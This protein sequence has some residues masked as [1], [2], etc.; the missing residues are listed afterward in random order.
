LKIPDEELRSALDE[1]VNSFQKDEL[2]Y[3]A[4]PGKSENPFRDRLAYVLHKRYEADGY[5]QGCSVRC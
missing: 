2:A 4:F 3:F 5:I 1:M